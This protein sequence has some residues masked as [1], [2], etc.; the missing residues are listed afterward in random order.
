MVLVLRDNGDRWRC[1]RRDCRTRNNTW[2][3]GS[4]IS[5]RDIVLLMYSWSR[6]MTSVIF[7]EHEFGSDTV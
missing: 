4:K 6:E 3:E 1:N 2:L 7:V 5:Y